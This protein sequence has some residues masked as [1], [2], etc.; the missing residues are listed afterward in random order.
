MHSQSVNASFMWDLTNQSVRFWINFLTEDVTRSSTFSVLSPTRT[1]CGLPLPGCWSIV[2]VRRTFFNRVSILPHFEHLLWACLT[3]TWIE[4]SYVYTK[5][6]LTLFIHKTTSCL[7][8]NLSFL[9]SV[10]SQS[11][12]VSLD[13]WGGKWNHLSM[14][15]RVST[16]S[17][18]KILQWET[19]C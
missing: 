12:A 13:R 17:M 9:C 2:P 3:D 18:P 16:E 7:R 10:I 14:T 19:Y 11:K 5:Y 4:I 8:L 6:C 15:H 1:W